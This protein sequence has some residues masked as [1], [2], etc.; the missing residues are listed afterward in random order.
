MNSWMHT[1][2]FL[3]LFSLLVGCG[4]TEA[5]SAANALAVTQAQNGGTTTLAKGGTLT[6]ELAGNPTTGYEWVVVQ[7]DATL[8]LPAEPTYESDS[9][10]IGSGGNYTF[11]FTAL[12]AGNA[13]LKL[14]YRRSWETTASDQTFTLTVNIQDAADSNAASLQDTQWKLADWSASSLNPANFSITA[15]FADGQI[16]GRSAVNHYS[17]SYAASNDGSFS[18]G[19]L[20][21]TLMAS[22]ENSMRAETLY[23]QLLAQARRYRIA[24]GQLIL[25]NASQQDLLIFSAGN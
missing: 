22:D 18:V 5:D 12:Q 13:S 4:G 24:Q 7:N 16:S 23:I 14:A 10:A 3:A 25:A 19:P 2:T 8:L 17:G 15:A 21:Q 6:I 20:T 9:S 1:G 11:R